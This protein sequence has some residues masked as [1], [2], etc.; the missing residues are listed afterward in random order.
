MYLLLLLLHIIVSFRFVSIHLPSCTAF[1]GSSAVLF[2]LIEKKWWTLYAVNIHP[3]GI[4]SS[5]GIHEA[6]VTIGTLKIV[7]IHPLP[8]THSMPL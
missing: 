7:Q 1:I 8:A 5:R 3:A 6:A 2:A 4:I